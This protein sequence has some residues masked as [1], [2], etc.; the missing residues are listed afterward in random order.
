VRASVIALP[1]E[2]A[3]L[4]WAALATRRFPIG[5]KAY[6][7]RREAVLEDHLEKLSEEFAG[8]SHL[9]YA[10]AILT[11]LIRR[12]LQ[13]DLA[14]RHFEAM[15]SSQAEHLLANL[16]ARWL[17]SACDTIMDCSDDE[18]ERA[19]AA[20]GSLFFN[21]IKLYETER[22]HSDTTPAPKGDVGAPVPLFDGL[23]TF[24]VGRGE[25]ISA[26]RER[27]K[28]LARPDSTAASIVLELLNRADRNDTVFQRFAAQHHHDATRW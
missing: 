16:S 27:I 11:V 7:Q 26:Q 1:L 18:Y 5:A 12:D 24:S 15:W 21:T 3:P 25:L 23:T 13:T 8:E 28:A 4:D 22:Y 19:M 9:S 10:H 20:A 6:M 2:D 14:F 17:I